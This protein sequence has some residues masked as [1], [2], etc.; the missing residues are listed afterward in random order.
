[1]V[2]FVPWVGG[3]ND[4]AAGWTL[5]EREGDGGVV[6]WFVSGPYRWTFRTF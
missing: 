6:G 5:N 4:R 2:R 1:M 3:L